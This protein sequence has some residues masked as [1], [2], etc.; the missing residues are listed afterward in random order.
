MSSAERAL[1][2]LLR[3]EAVTLLCAL[4]AVVMPTEWMASA[5]AWLGL[6]EMARSP[7]VEYLTRSISMLYAGWGPVL[8]VLSS[9]VRRYLPVL[10]VY[11]WLALAY[12]PALVVLDLFA[13]MPTWW[14]AGE[15]A[16]VIALGT[17]GILLVWR[18]Q[19]EQSEPGTS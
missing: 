19:K 18:T 15:G 12:G 9:D 3:T 17:A 16:T 10:W 2:W 8:W 11:S 7:L 6:G 1:V 13:G 4:P 14:V 5:H